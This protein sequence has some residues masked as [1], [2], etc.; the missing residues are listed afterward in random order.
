VGAEGSPAE[1]LVGVEAA[2]FENASKAGG[3]ECLL[4][5]KSSCPK[6]GGL[7]PGAALHMHY[8]FL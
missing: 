5:V 3:Q 1:D 4:H 7:F 6:L 2:H 8:R